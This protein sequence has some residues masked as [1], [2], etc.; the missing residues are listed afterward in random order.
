M[1]SINQINDVKKALE[2]EGDIAHNEQ[3]LSNLLSERF[4][5]TPEPPRCWNVERGDYPPIE[6]KTKFNPWL[7]LP[8]FWFFIFFCIAIPVSS[9][10]M[11][12]FLLLTIFWIP[13]YIAY[14]FIKKDQEKTKIRNSDEYKNKCK[15]VDIEFDRLKAKCYEAYQNAM[16][17]YENETMPAYNNELEAWTKE[18]NQKISDVKNTLN[19]AR[20]K[21]DEHYR[22][23]QIVPLQYREI[24]VLRYI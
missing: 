5:A 19:N 22:S 21:L 17:V 10:L 11:I 7:L 9:F 14:V 8:V 4:K 23:T 18:H 2:L 6:P 12:L 15:A 13:G 16:T 24:K 3:V 20:N 1:S